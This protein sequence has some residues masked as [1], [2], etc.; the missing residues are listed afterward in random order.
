VQYIKK[1]SQTYRKALPILKIF[2]KKDKRH[3]GYIVIILGFGALMDLIGIFLVG[4]VGSLITSYLI[5]VEMISF[6]VSFIDI[7]GLENYPKKLLI[8]YCSLL[9]VLFFLLK[10]IFSIYTNRKILLFY[11]KKQREFS[12]SLFSKVLDSSYVWLKKQ[13]AEL[14]FSAITTGADAIFMRL[15]GNLILIISDTLLLFFILTSLIIFNPIASLLTFFYFL[16]IALFLQKI[17]GKRAITYGSVLTESSIESHRNLNTILASFKEI[18]V[19][20]KKNYFIN[21]FEN[22]EYLKST[23]AA[24]SIWVQQLPKYIFEI[25]LTLG[26]FLLSFFLLTSNVNNISTLTLFIVAG[27]RLVPA[28]FRIQSGLFNLASGYPNALLAIEFL[29]DLQLRKDLVLGATDNILKTPP[30]IEIQ[31]VCFRFPDSK[32]YLLENI[33]LDIASGEVV[34][35]VGKSGSGKSTLVDLIL[36]I[37]I[38][39]KG[40]I[41]LKDGL[42]EVIPGSMTNISYVPQHPIIF[43]GTV[44][45][46]I[47][48]G[49]DYNNISQE[50]LDYAIKSANLDEL[51][52]RLPE[53][54]NT[55]LNTVGGILSGGEKQRIAIA[56]A[57]YLKPKFLVIDEGTS[58]LD[59]TSEDFITQTLMSLEGKVTIIII[60]HRITTIKKVKN[61]YFMGNGKI[62]GVGNYTSLQKSVPEFENWAQ[63]INSNTST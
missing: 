42:N 50:S 49:T 22:S 45:Q 5:G 51:I 24:K 12:V 57:L 44:L 34:A 33:S 14:I 43:S 9:I 21:K 4:V 47:V 59:Y 8:V 37:Y 31:S 54:V 7:V 30:S 10:T 17:I 39:S 16:L 56:R 38:P 52:K 53:G 13:N 3:F 29:D 46:N 25:G 27:G 40:R 15:V 61:I 62:L 28:L 2:S 58:S 35:F 18:F 23:V 19:M 26:V 1:Y 63:Q 36:N 60:A 32:N 20:N 55:E 6:V 41:V 48:F 11:A